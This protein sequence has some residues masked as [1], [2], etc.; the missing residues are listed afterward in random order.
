[1][2]KERF[3][4]V[5][6]PIKDEDCEP[7][8]F[9]TL[10]DLVNS[11]PPS[12]DNI[13]KIYRLAD[14]SYH[15][16]WEPTSGVFTYHRVYDR[17]FPYLGDPLEIFDFTYSATRMG[18]AP[19]ISAQG[20]M[21]YADL[22]GHTLDG[23]WTQECHVVFNGSKFHLRQIP[24]SSKSNEDARY[25]Y[26]MDFIDESVVLESVYFYDVVQPFI[27]EKP[28]SENSVFSFYGD[29]SELAKRVNASLIRSGLASLIRKY[30]HYDDP[31]YEQVL[32]STIIPYLTYE[33]WNMMNVNPMSL[34]PEVFG[35]DYEWQVFRYEI[36]RP[37]NG[38]YNSY[39]LDYI[40]ENDNG[41]YALTGY[42]C[43]IGNDKYGN[44]ST[45]EEKLLSFDNNTIHEALQQFHD[46]FE[47]QYYVVKERDSIGD[48]T[49]NTL[50]MVADCEHDF[51]DIDPV[52]GDFVRDDEGIPTTDN[53]FD[54]GVNDELLSKTKT[55]TTDK[56]VT[57]ITGVGSSENIPWHY[58]NP[59][60]DGWIK[61][62]F[63]RNGVEMQGVTIDYPID[64]GTT[65][66]DSA[67][68][69]K[70]LKNRIGVPIKRGA[71]KH[72]IYKNDYISF[73]EETESGTLIIHTVY[74]INTIGVFAPRVALEMSYNTVN[75]G[76]SKLTAGLFMWSYDSSQTYSEPNAFQ[77]MFINADGKHNVELL[78]GFYYD[79]NIDY[80]IPENNIPLS[81][82]YDYEG[83][84]YPSQTIAIGLTGLNTHVGENFYNVQGLQPYVDWAIL[85]QTTPAVYSA[86]YSTNG[87]KSGKVTPIPRE[88][89]KKYKDLSTGIIYE[90]TDS[91]TPSYDTNYQGTHIDAF[92]ANPLMSAEE[93]L[94]RNVYNLVISLYANDGWYLKG[95]KIIL[96]DYGL[97]EPIQNGAAI[98]TDIFDIIEFQR[99]KWVTPQ[100]NLMPEVFIKTDGERRFYNAHNYWDKANETLL[101][102]TADTMIGEQQ[103]GT[104]VRNPLYKEEETDTDDKHYDFEN[105][106]IQSLP[107]EHIEN[108]DDVKPS[109]KGQ[110]NYV[111]VVVDKLVIDDWANQYQNYFIQDENGN[112]VQAPS[113]YD[114]N[115]DYYIR[116]RIDVVEEF[117]YDTYDD[118]E[119]WESGDNS[120]EYKHPYFFAKL[121]PL[122]FNIFDLA[123]Q[124]DMVL[125]MT[126][127]NCGACNFRIGVDENYRKN[128]VQLWEYDVYR[129]DIL[130]TATKVFNKGDLRR[131]TNLIGLYYNTNNQQSGYTPVEKGLG[132]IEGSSPAYYES[133]IAVFRRYQYTGESVEKGLVGTTKQNGKN[134]FEGDVVTNGKFIDS[135]QDTTDNYVWVAL[136]K[137]TDS[138]GT[139]MPSSIPNYNDPSLNQYIRPKSIA[140]VHD[141]YSTGAQ[142]EENADKFVLTNIRLPQIYLRRA[143]HE[144]SRKLVNYMYEHNYQ[145]FNFSMKFSRIYVEE[146]PNT[147]DNLNENSVL[148]VSYNNATY[149]QYVKSYTYTMKHDETLPELNV[150]M[151]EELSVSRTLEE[152]RR[153]DGKNLYGSLSS[154]I[155]SKVK[156]S[157][158]IIEGRTIG[159]DS[160]HI[161]SGNIIIQGMD[162][163]LVELARRV[164]EVGNT[165]VEEVDIESITN[166]EIDDICV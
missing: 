94:R 19:T 44:P 148:Y 152:K 73:S 27:N 41:V 24:D 7:Q 90:C 13:N 81:Q 32:P 98:T 9:A 5:M 125:S 109:I 47:L 162:T 151:N 25:K 140:D 134:H 59:C 38:D 139:L 48:F 52:S 34:V 122:G 156:K 100:P 113:V 49:G 108:F 144:L 78:Q 2:A 20:V 72:L 106:Y 8:V 29:I 101:V 1:M 119:I 159:R 82:D 158:D 63:T 35:S 16:V 89:G 53:P 145:K 37:L 58:P 141:D 55:N 95:E 3:L 84:F 104:F 110:M 33:Q 163:S 21:R 92:D 11:V 129:G 126:T 118:N 153:R 62:F 160:N 132:V 102:G 146:N 150:D 40:Y 117:A 12:L 123:L 18:S 76:I 69:E 50:I 111:L 57:R 70:F 120:G 74:Y 61:P 43:K 157:Q 83:Y 116:L 28:V 10:S 154:K 26:D 66:A 124:E 77:S 14:G 45:S 128:P 6:V 91:E 15:R 149:R 143:E 142:D 135:Q 88:R 112:F 79:F 85:G 114:Y 131:Y 64:E 60:P 166:A 130:A 80:Y 46:T 165:T 4:T 65:T 115:E 136:F 54:Y 86:G 107:H 105:E 51:A 121:R 42:Q 99:L 17:E 30:V 87:E 96:A 22:D 127:G 155:S 161:M 137:D 36:Y 164:G 75:S 68:Y 56:I 23:L 71:I 93:W 103:V 97:E 67:R 39:L 147:D 138:Y 133:D 31:Y